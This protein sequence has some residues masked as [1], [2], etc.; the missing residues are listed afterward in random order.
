MPRHIHKVAKSKPTKLL[1]QDIQDARKAKLEARKELLE[2]NAHL[3]LHSHKVEVAEK[4]KAQQQEPEKA[5][6]IASAK[7]VEAVA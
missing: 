1:V 3:K 6:A 5:Q 2:Q 4:P 7:P